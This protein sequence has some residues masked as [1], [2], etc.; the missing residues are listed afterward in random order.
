[1]NIAIDTSP[2]VIDQITP[3]DIICTGTNITTDIIIEV[4][5]TKTLSGIALDKTNTVYVSRE[6]KATFYFLEIQ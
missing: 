4:I 1:M 3:I 2:P 5:A 6:A